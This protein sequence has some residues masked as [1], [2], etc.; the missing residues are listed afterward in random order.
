[1]VLVEAL[2]CGCPIVSTDAPG[3]AEVVGDL[4]IIVPRGNVEALAA[5]LGN[6]L[7][8][9]RGTFAMQAIRR[10]RVLATFSIEAVAQRWLDL[11]GSLSGKAVMPRVEVA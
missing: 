6:T 9:G 11:Y 3:V 5:A 1:M 2:A 7:R 8:A 10:D 4:G